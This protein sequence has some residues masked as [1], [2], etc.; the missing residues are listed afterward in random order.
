MDNLIQT[1]L[2]R[3]ENTQ[4]REEENIESIWNYTIGSLFLLI[5]LIKLIKLAYDY[6]T[7]QYTDKREK[8]QEMKEG[9][10]AQNLY[11]N[12]EKITAGN[13]NYQ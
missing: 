6:F 8:K 9:K 11:R 3:R 13:M 7:K 12:L 1:R 10:A 5:V 4:F 2:D